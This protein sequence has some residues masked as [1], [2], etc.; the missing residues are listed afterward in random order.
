MSQNNLT[1]WYTTVAQ[2]MVSSLPFQSYE[3][4]YG[5]A[6][7][8]LSNVGGW[9]PVDDTDPTGMG[10]PANGADEPTAAAAITATE[11]SRVYSSDITA[12]ITVKLNVQS[13]LTPGLSQASVLAAL[14]EVLQALLTEQA[15]RAPFEVLTVEG[16]TGTVTPNGIQTAAQMVEVNS[17][18]QN[19]EKISD[20]RA[21]ALIAA[22][23]RYN[24]DTSWN[25]SK[26]YTEADQSISFIIEK[27]QSTA[28]LARDLS[29]SK[30]YQIILDPV[31]YQVNTGTVISY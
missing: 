21:L 17:I 24:L 16:V 25:V 18:T 28:Y 23:S 10:A 14:Q 26:V 31:T 4:G 30:F 11:Y 27:F 5:L 9:V 3:D 15:I 8:Y 20:S 13:Y 19:S 6:E 22:R 12:T 29:V 2:L 7:T 1:G